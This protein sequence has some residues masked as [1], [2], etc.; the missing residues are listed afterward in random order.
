MTVYS[1]TSIAMDPS[2]GVHIGYRILNDSNP[3]PWFDLKY[4]SNIG[5][6]W[7]ISRVD[8]AGNAFTH[9]PV[10]IALSS[11]ESVHIGYSNI[12]S[13]DGSIRLAEGGPPSWNITEV[14]AGGEIGTMCLDSQGYSHYCIGVMVGYVPMLA[15]STNRG[16]SWSMEIIDGTNDTYYA[17]ITVDLEDNV[18]V[19]YTTA[20]SWSL[21]YVTNSG[22]SWETQLV[23]SSGQYGAVAF[24]T[25]GTLYV[26]YTVED[27]VKLAWLSGGMW[28]NETVE[29]SPPTDIWPSIAVDAWN[30][31]HLCY[32]VGTEESSI[33]TY[34]HRSG[35]NWTKSVVEQFDSSLTP[36]LGFSSIAAD[37][38]GYVHIAYVRGLMNGLDSGGGIKYAT[39]A[40][41]AIP[42]M[43]AAMVV[44]C[45]L[46]ITALVLVIRWRLV[47]Y[48]I[49]G[50][51]P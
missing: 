9:V 30:D 29:S 47:G 23:D 7:N 24:D 1:S 32:T 33:L 38:D 45:F 15:Y 25:L 41:P 36:Y 8:G 20:P 6:V 34:A 49:P 16:G 46:A 28:S 37:V 5:S 42:E 35:S 40:A 43:N 26:V 2:N 39:N 3:G 19:L 12:S 50:E 21:H 18:H 14:F 17:C 11:S 13:G 4:A 22:G 31:I 27:S 48:R 44:P 10:S 51:K